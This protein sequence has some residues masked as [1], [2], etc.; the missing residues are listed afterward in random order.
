MVYIYIYIG[1]GGGGGDGEQWLLDRRIDRNKN[2][3]RPNIWSGPTIEISSDVSVGE[4]AGP[5]SGGE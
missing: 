4:Q 3:G 5:M 2:R 1:G